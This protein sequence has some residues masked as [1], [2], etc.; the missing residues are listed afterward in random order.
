M[1]REDPGQRHPGVL[2]AIAPQLEEIAASFGTPR[3]AEVFARVYPQ[4]QSISID[5]AVLEPRSAKG[6]QGAE[7]FCLPA[8]FGWNDLGSWNALYDHHSSY[9]AQPELLGSNVLHAGDG[10]AIE[11]A[12]NYV[13]APER[14]VALL[15]VED[16]VVVVTEDA[17][18]VT[19]RERSQEVGAVTRALAEAGRTELL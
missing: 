17:V 4:C 9:T 18:L 16:L 7:I 6:E 14:T 15:G 19:T 10:L 12:G 11:A 8:E 1:E 13:Y 2:P 5:Y 3:F